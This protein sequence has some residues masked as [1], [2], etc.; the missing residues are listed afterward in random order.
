VIQAGDDM[1][2]EAVPDGQALTVARNVST[3]YIAIAIEA[4][5]GLV[6]LPFNV[7]HLGAAAYGL[8]ML[9]ASVTA[10]FS[11]L[12]LGYSGAM[13]K[14]VAQYRAQRDG[15]ALNEILSTL[16]FLFTAFGAAIYLAAILVAFNLG[17]IFSLTPDQ[18]H[19]GR[20]VLLIISVNVAL[21]SAF[22]VYGGVINGFQRYDL[23]NMVGALS[24]VVA[25]AANVGALLLG[26]GLVGLVAATTTVRVLTYAIYRANAYRVFPHLRIRAS[27]FR[28]S[29]LREV[30]TFSVFMLLIDWA[31]KLN[32]SVDAI[33]IGFALSTTAVAVWTVAERLAEVTQR[34]TNQL[35][36]VLFPLIVNDDTEARNARLQQ[37]FVQ[38]TRLSLGTVVPLG[39][40]LMLMAAPLVRAWVGPE[41]SGSVILVQLLSLVVIMRVGNATGATLLKGA[42]RH[43]LLAF[44]NI[45]A[46]ISNLALSLLLVR[47]LGLV[48]VAIGTM[49]PI[50]IAAAF[51]VFPA[52]CRRVGLPLGTAL[53]QAVWPALWPAGLMV[54]AARLMRGLAPDTLIAVG[55]QIAALCLVYAV[56]FFFF[57]LSADERRFYLSK[58]LQL[59]AQWHPAVTEGA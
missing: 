56:T 16:F 35:S 53:I 18:V 19:T 34:L 4:A 23:N 37:I 31:N 52:A 51:V 13:V 55:A 29:R 3:R 42:G 44:T 11:V 8:W 54:V 1:L 45:T 21:S 40:A 57:S 58:A 14:F 2:V 9:T 6:V 7:A 36:D 25:A 43:R 17:S 22:S 20:I 10:Y 30:T 24:S 48:G 28:V 26:Y 12:D 41:F 50:G 33:V 38:A 15:R 32:Y 49:V 39:G 27:L 46:A 47:W 59:K 5:V